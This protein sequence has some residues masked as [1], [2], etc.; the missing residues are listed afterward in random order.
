MQFVFFVESGDLARRIK[1]I[2]PQPGGVAVAVENQRAFALDSSIRGND[3]DGFVTK[4][5]GSGA[6]NAVCPR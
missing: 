2:V 6:T 3:G 1:R 5:A 4:A